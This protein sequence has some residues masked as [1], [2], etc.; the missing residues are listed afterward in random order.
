MKNAKN[1][2]FTIASILTIATSCAIEAVTNFELF[3]KASEPINYKLSIYRRQ[4]L[5]GNIES[6]EKS[7]EIF[8]LKNENVSEN[9]AIYLE[10]I[11]STGTTKFRIVAPNKTKYVTWNPAKSPSLYPQTGPMWGLKGTTESGLP[12]NNNVTQSQ[13]TELK[14]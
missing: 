4:I 14:Q 8:D 6:N 12:L 7:K 13:I 2:F 10:I 1:I 11:T 5:Y 3:N 9:D